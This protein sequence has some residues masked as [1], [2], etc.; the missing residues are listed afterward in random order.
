MAENETLDLWYR[1]SGRWRDLWRLIIRDAAGEELHR[2]AEYC[3]YKTFQNLRKLIPLPEILVA[4]AD[5]NGDM[6]EIVR[7]CN[8]GR[9]YAQLFRLEANQG[10]SREAIVGNVAQATL[11][12]FLDQMALKIL[13]DDGRADLGSLGE[14]FAHLKTSLE[15]SIQ[16]LADQVAQ[17][18]DRSPR[19]RAATPETKAAEHARLLD[20]SVLGR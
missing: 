3:L 10:L 13:S 11:Q 18:P 16:R 2:Q 14:R 1:N 19:R 8:E 17:R 5:G 15:P 12:R 4:A 9:E 20:M 7:N 6:A